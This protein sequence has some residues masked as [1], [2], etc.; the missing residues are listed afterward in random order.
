M[1]RQNAKGS[2]H[3]VKENTK[4]RGHAQDE[5]NMLEECKSMGRN[6]GRDVGR[7]IGR[8]AKLSRDSLKEEIFQ[9]EEKCY[10]IC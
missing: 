5:N 6:W 3:E 9:E 7:Q 4:G 1:K 8:E 2:E 10:K